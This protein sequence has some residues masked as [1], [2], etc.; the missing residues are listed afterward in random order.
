MIRARSMIQLLS[1]CVIAACVAFSPR[2]SLAAPHAVIVCG[3]GG[4]QEYSARFGEWGRR[5]NDALVDRCG[6]DPANVALMLE[7]GEGSAA[8]PDAA[9][10]ESIRSRFDALEAQISQQDDL[11]VFLIGHGSYMRGESRFLIAGDD[12]TAEMFGRMLAPVTAERTALYVLTSSSAGWINGLSGSDRTIVTATR[13]PG[14]RE[15]VEITEHLIRALEEGS[16]DIDRD[17]RISVLE[18]TRQA[19]A[20]TAQWYEQ[21]GIILTEHA[22]LDDNGDGLGT[23]LVSEEEVAFGAMPAIEQGEDGALAARIFLKDFQFPDGAPPEL[24][25]RYLALLNDVEELKLEKS[26]LDEDEYLRRLEALLV[27]AARA[28]REIRSY[29]SADDAEAGAA[30]MDEDAIP[31]AE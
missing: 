30:R 22:L 2:E 29:R 11:H 9:S 17:E 5:L 18:L 6:F 20:L 1:I 7:P 4:N 13:S 31:C 14:Q 3:A 19:A 10:L 8:S 28:H 21:Q 25:Q 24:V 15:A 27:E 16:A 26:A 12:L 23:R